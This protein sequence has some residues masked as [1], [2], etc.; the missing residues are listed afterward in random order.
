MQHRK[1]FT[2]MGNEEK[3]ISYLQMICMYFLCK[4]SLGNFGTAQLKN[5]IIAYNVIF[6]D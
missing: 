1:K 6:K 3:K 2:K 5:I 4:V